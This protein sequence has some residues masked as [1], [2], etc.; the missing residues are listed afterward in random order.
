M[1]IQS[2]SATQNMCKKYNL[3]PLKLE[4][5][6]QFWVLLELYNALLIQLLSDKA[7]QRETLT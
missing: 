6:E 3:E 7:R 5:A 1:I 4:A 2:T